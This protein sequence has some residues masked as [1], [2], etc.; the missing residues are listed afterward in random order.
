MARVAL[1]VRVAVL[2]RFTVLAPHIHMLAT[3][4]TLVRLVVLLPRVPKVGALRLRLLSGDIERIQRTALDAVSGNHPERTRKNTQEECVRARAE[5]GG[6]LEV[7]LSHRVAHRV[8]LCLHDFG[9]PAFVLAFLG[10]SFCSANTSTFHIRNQ[11]LALH[12]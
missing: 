4:V 11:K 8:E 10:F 2:A 6:A 3:V 5:R 1:P 7:V 9:L 12:H